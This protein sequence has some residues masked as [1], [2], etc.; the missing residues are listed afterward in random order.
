M[1]TIYFNG[2]PCHTAG[3]LPEVGTKAACYSFVTPELKEIHCADFHGKRVVLN[4]FPS[5]DTPV[6]AA[7]VRRFNNEAASLE[8]PW[9]SACRWTYPSR[10]DASV[11]PTELPT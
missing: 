8:I 5:L 7:S 1:E 10:P 11:R 4:V 3:T 2:I 9:C 6:C